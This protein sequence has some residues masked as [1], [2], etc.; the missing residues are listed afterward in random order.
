MLIT[1]YANGTIVAKIM[2]YINPSTP[3]EG[4]NITHTYEELWNMRPFQTYDET[5]ERFIEQHHTN[6]E[7]GLNQTITAFTSDYALYWFDY[8]AGYDVVLAQFGW[9]HTTAQDIAL[10]IGA[11][12]L[13]NKS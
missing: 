3:V 2:D 8:L 12:Y 4:Y 5:A 11:A 10:I 9:N 1:Y 7:R 13:Q 6:L